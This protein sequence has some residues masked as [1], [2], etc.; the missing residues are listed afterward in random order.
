ML[1]RVRC[2]PCPLIVFKVRPKGHGNLGLQPDGLD[3]ADGAL[4][5]TPHWAAS[6]LSRPIPIVCEGRL[7]TFYFQALA[8]WRKRRL[9][10]GGNLHFNIICN[11]GKGPASI[12]QRA[13]DE[14]RRERNQVW[15]AMDVENTN[16]GAFRTA[17]RRAGPHGISL[18]LTNPSFDAWA[19]A[20]MGPLIGFRDCTAR[21]YKN[22]L[23]SK[24]G[25]RF[26]QA[27]AA[28]FLLKIFGDNFSN[29]AMVAQN[30]TIFDDPE[31][32]PDGIP[33]TNLNQLLAL[34]TSGSPC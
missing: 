13:I 27:I 21:G 9:D 16:S 26:I 5:V 1:P 25:E 30:I 18:A 8:V 34:F 31:Q 24:V 29:L 19:L 22:A 17:I 4:D 3:N 32:V 14:V 20:H 12:V 6:L 28:P 7:E 2:G 10:G 23:E 15:C 33:S 11:D